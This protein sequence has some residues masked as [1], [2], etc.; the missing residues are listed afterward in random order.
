MNYRVPSADQ[1]FNPIDFDLQDCK[2]AMNHLGEKIQACILVFVMAYP[3][4]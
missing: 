3:L 1:E 4:A 2:N